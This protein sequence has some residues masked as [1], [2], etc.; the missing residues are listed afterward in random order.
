MKRFYWIIVALLALTSCS[1]S[2]FYSSEKDIKDGKWNAD[3]IAV[4]TVS[5][6]DTISPY[7]LFFSITN[8]E[9]YM[10][11]NI[12]LFVTIDF[13]HGIQRVDTVDCLLADERGKWFGKEVDDG[14]YRNFLLYRKKVR[15]PYKGKYVFRFEQA[16]RHKVL[17]G[18]YQVGLYIKKSE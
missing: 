10:Y 3:S 8:G 2:Y 16:M 5:I 17:D 11:R 1:E 12:Y 4:F 7:D 18:I 6:E 15:F 9:Q 13:P 14:K